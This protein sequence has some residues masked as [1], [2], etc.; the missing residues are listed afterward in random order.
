VRLLD[1]HRV[2]AGG[3]DGDVRCGHDEVA[4]RGVQLPK[5]D[6]GARRSPLEDPK[7]ADHATGH[8]VLTDV[9]VDQ[10]AGGLASVVPVGRNLEFAHG[11]RFNPTSP[12]RQWHGG[13]SMSLS[14][15]VVSKP[16]L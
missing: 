11:V 10:R 14:P 3:W 12:M 9:E 1:D 8:G 15:H 2:L 13:M 16:W 5:G 6:V 7:G 4:H